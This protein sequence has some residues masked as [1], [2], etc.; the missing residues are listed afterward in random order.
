MKSREEETAVSLPARFSL[1]VSA[2]TD[3][4]GVGCEGRG[5]VGSGEWEA[6]ASGE[7]A[8]VMCRAECGFPG[9]GLR[10]GEFPG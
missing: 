5:T 4:G 9:E 7:V 6:E 3:L 10:A 2:W 8:A 1:G